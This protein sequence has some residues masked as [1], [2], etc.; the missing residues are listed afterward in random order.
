MR[1][2]VSRAWVL[3]RLKTTAGT[4]LC[5]VCTGP[6]VDVPSLPGYASPTLDVCRRCHLFWFDPT[7]FEQVPAVPQVGQPATSISL[8]GQTSSGL[9]PAAAELLALQRASAE[10]ERLKGSGSATAGPDAWWQWIPGL[11]GLPVELGSRV[12]R[13]AWATWVLAAVITAVSFVAFPDLPGAVTHF[14]LIP[15]HADR[16]FGLTLVSSFLLHGSVLHL[17]GNLYYLI[18]F[19][20]NVEDY[21]G[22]R[23]FLL[24][25][26]L[27]ALV[28]DIAHVALDRRSEVPL[29][30]ASGG[31]SGLVAFY[32]LQYPRA[33]LAF[34]VFFRW[35]RV[36]AYLFLV[37]W[38]GLQT[39]T[40]WQQVSGLTSVSALA[41]LGGAAVGVWC[42]LVWRNG[43]RKRV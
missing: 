13:V 5:P 17:L 20:D 35:I 28:G 14:G 26:V 7:E 22:H 37:F 33:K 25:V 9:P 34:V 15:A 4:R 24:L 42:W 12:S 18:L 31:I 11:L 36:P 8:S 41:H 1:D 32:G 2:Y 23:R 38:L 27:A 40:A 3:A 16:H 6:M 21:L 29:I 30:G 39:L 19:G 10:A 43:P